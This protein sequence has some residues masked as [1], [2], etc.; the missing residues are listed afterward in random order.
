MVM[1]RDFW[2]QALETQGVTL[3]R[4]VHCRPPQYPQFSARRG[5]IL[6]TAFRQERRF[7]SKCAHMSKPN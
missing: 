1:A 6:E 3:L 5:D 2:F 7:P 4:F